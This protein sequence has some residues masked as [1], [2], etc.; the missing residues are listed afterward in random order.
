M[1]R[2]WL[3]A[4]HSVRLG[5]LVGDVEQFVGNLVVTACVCVCAGHRNRPMHNKNTFHFGS[6]S[7]GPILSV[8]ECGCC[9]GH[10]ANEI[11]IFCPFELFI[12][13][14]RMAHCWRLTQNM[15]WHTN[16][17]KEKNGKEFMC[18]EKNGRQLGLVS[19]QMSNIHMASNALSFGSANFSIEVFS[20]PPNT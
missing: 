5:V 16:M 2:Y 8:F 1:L 14:F 20:F 6:L 15:N 12:C 4:A 3:R 13:A 7:I 19:Q 9:I 18:T 11:I 17:A 10:I